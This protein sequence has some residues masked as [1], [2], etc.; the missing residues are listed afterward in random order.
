MAALF[1]EDWPAHG[2]VPETIPPPRQ[3]PVECVLHSGEVGRP[4]SLVRFH[5]EGPSKSTL[6]LLASRPSGPVIGDSADA[7]TTDVFATPSGDAHSMSS[8][9]I[10]HAPKVQSKL[11]SA[12]D[13]AFQ[14]PAHVETLAVTALDQELDRKPK[15][16][17]FDDASLTKG[18]PM[19]SGASGTSVQSLFGDQ[20]AAKSSKL[21]SLFHDKIPARESL[22]VAAPQVRPANASLFGEGEASEPASLFGGPSAPRPPRGMF[23][24]GSPQEVPAKVDIFGG[25]SAP[26]S[27][28]EKALHPA[29]C[30]ACLTM[31]NRRNRRRRPL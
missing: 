1:D 16:S 9:T 11:A 21:A 19:Q 15:V 31:A 12:Q 3:A 7:L 24:G 25:V 28:S 29:Y 23:G 5:D 30:V 10:E 2:S 17:A 18:M 22:P 4:E 27:F 8:S 6:G 20:S 14:G 13:V 26:G